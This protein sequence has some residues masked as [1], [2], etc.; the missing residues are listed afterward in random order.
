M[1]LPTHKGREKS[2]NTELSF[3]PNVKVTFSIENH[4]QEHIESENISETEDEDEDEMCSPIYE[5]SDGDYSDSQNVNCEV[6]IQDVQ[7]CPLTP[8]NEPKF[9]V[10]WIS[11]LPLFQFCFVCFDKTRIIPVELY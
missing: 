7:P 9:L 5:D 1:K 11:L 3:P 8:V 2:V 6:H 10:F 4:Y